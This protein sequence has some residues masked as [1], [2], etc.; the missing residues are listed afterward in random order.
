MG[1]ATGA[2]LLE[3]LTDLE[4][5]VGELANTWRPDDPA[6]RA[7]VYRQTMMSL[8]YS[9]F[10]YFHATPEHPDW[11]PL[12]NPVYTLQPNPDDLY[13]YSPIRGDLSYRISGNRGTCA[14]VT[15][16]TTRGWV[17]MVERTEM[18]FGRDFDD[19]SLETDANGDFELLLSA[20]RPEGHTGNWAEF[21]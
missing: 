18:G 1:N 14:L 21:A 12:W 8:S 11:A 2:T 10:A 15:F 4:G 7:D 6:Y 20:R 3:H 19:R 17:G 9:Y 16:N 13:L 5:A